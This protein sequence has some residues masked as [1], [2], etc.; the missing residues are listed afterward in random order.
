MLS[1]YP[2]TTVVTLTWLCV[3]VWLRYICIW[4]CIIL[5]TLY[6]YIIRH[7]YLVAA[8]YHI[9]TTH[10]TM[11]LQVLYW[12]LSTWPLVVTWSF[13]VDKLCV[14]TTGLQSVIV[15]TY[16]MTKG[17]WTADHHSHIWVSPWTF[18][19]VGSIKI[20]FTGTKTIH[21]ASSIKT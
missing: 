6:S 12:E 13:G 15:H 3:C 9:S 1:H 4:Y 20:P 14:A 11:S 16:Y 21:N 7:T 8:L 10:S 5:N 18:H 17:L 19:K 2:S